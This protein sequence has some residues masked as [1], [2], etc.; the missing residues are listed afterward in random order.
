MDIF[1]LIFAIILFGFLAFKH[2]NALVLAPLVTVF[3][4]VC[5]GLPILESLKE[6]FMP[7]AA[8]YVA[9]YFLIFFV[10]ALFG[11]IYQLFK[12]ENL[13]RRLIPSAI[14]AGCWTWSM[15]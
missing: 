5:S 8:D 14:S 15:P 2:M 10:G 6:S 1:I 13:T 4:A 12:K 7:A 11:T 3:V 9:D